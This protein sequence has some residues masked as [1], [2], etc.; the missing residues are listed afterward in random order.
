MGQNT[1]Q[2]LPISGA[3]SFEGLEKYLQPTK[4]GRHNRHVALD[5]HTKI[6][7]QINLATQKNN[8]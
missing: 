1:A 3:C 8:T 2:I 4:T 5:M 7:V 6:P